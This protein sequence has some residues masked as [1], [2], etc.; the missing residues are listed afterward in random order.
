M[1]F[2]ANLIKITLISVAYQLILG[3]GIFFSAATVHAATPGWDWTKSPSTEDWQAFFKFSDLDK[4]KEWTRLSAKDI[5]FEEMSWEWKLAWVRSCTFSSTKDCSQIVQLG[6]F[7]KALVVRAEAATRLGQRFAGS[8]YR[9]AIRLL[10]TAYGIQQNIRK[11]EPLF[12]QYRILQALNKIGGEGAEV[13][14]QLA[15]NSTNMHK[16]WTRIASAK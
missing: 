14:K 13:G 11:K 8:G 10:R 1:G 9:P 2:S 16:Y 4:A 7:D 3:L 6:L 5:D 15:M 12:V